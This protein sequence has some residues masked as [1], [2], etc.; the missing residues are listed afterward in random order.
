MP[1]CAD[2]KG[3]ELLR[4]VKATVQALEPL[5]GE[6]DV[7]FRSKAS[8]ETGK[9]QQSI[10]FGG[11]GKGGNGRLPP[12]A[13]DL[14]DPITQVPATTRYLGRQTVAGETYEVVELRQP[15][16]AFRLLIGSDG[17]I[18]RAFSQ[19][20]DADKI[21]IVVTSY[22][23]P[24]AF[25]PRLPLPPPDYRFK[26]LNPD[27]SNKRFP[28]HFAPSPDGSRL[29]VVFMDNSAQIVDGRQGQVLVTLEGMVSATI[30]CLCAGRQARGGCR[31]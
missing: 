23:K 20:R 11:N 30:G 28:F 10:G 1:A 19:P 14:F 26:F 25:A 9:Y 6:Y 29:L 22:R 8:S 3:D 12:E 5:I 21:E 18:H 7:T 17:L 2:E 24:R 4:Q 31:V 13:F 15:R 16:F 27:R